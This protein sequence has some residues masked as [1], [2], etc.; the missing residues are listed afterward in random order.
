[1][2]KPVFDPCSNKWAEKL[3]TP[4]GDLEP[5]DYIDLRKHLTQ[6]AAC[7]N[8]LAES[9]ALNKKVSNLLPIRSTSVFIPQL[10]QHL[11]QLWKD[12]EPARRA[13]ALTGTQPPQNNTIYRRIQ[14]RKLTQA[15]SEDDAT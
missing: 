8:A 14:N 1:M 13:R 9:E 5:K 2:E 15:S 4:R 12:K 3:A 10:P 6:C 7:S 11:Q